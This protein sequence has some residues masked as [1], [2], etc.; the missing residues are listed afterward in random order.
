MLMKERNNNIDILKA[1]CVFEVV[2]AH[3]PFIKFGIITPRF[4]VPCF[5][6]ISGYFIYSPDKERRNEKIVKGIKR[7]GWI[8][9]WSTMVYAIF[10]GF[11]R[12][13]NGETLITL[14]DAAKWLFFNE[15]VFDFHLWYLF[16]YLYV[17][18]LVYFLNKK[19]WLSLL[20]WAVP[21]LLVYYLLFGAY[22]TL[23]LGKYFPL[24]LTRNFLSAGLPFFTIGMWIKKS[25]PPHGCRSLAKWLP[26]IIAI[27]STL[28]VIARSLQSHTNFDP[29]VISLLLSLSLFL[30]AVL[31]PNS[32]PNLLSKIGREDTLYIYVFHIL[33]WDVSW[34]VLSKLSLYSVLHFY[35]TYGAPFVLVLTIILIRTVR[36]AYRYLLN[37]M[38]LLK[39]C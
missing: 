25:T 36:W 17:L 38:N 20:K 27:N 26:Y 18:V 12:L 32:R 8:S 1:I 33:V 28:W 15:T 4:A 7:I 23:I 13:R 30:W 11:F 24:C 35:E 16:A 31:A 29:C 9:L 10:M 39:T 2:F 6:M 3:I 22:N 21:I 5:L 14:K 34:A 19:G 37:T